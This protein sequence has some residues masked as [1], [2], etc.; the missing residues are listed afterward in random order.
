VGRSLRRFCLVVALL[1]SLVAGPT[2]A[3]QTAAPQQVLKTEPYYLSFF[4]ASG[5]HRGTIL[6]L[7]GGGWI[8][9]KGAGADDEM[10]RWIDA[11]VSWG[12]DV[13]NL[14]YR[15]GAPA[16]VDA[17]DAFE[18][19]RRRVGPDERLCIF[20]GSAGA[21][22]GLFVAAERGKDVDCVVDLLGP[23][24]LVDFGSQPAAS[25]GHQ[26]AVQ[27]FGE[28]R[29]AELS[30]IN[31]VDRI[32]APVLVVAAP[33]DIFI[34]LSAQERFVEALNAAGGS[35][36]LQVVETGEDIPL[37]HCNVDGASF[38]DF[39]DV[40]RRFLAGKPLPAMATDDDDGFGLSP[41]AILG[42]VVG[43]VGLALLGRRLSPHN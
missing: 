36:R 31:M 14:G 37:G 4:E 20:G 38:L 24:D 32:V 11:V 7:H 23:P 29:L 34:E 21:Q 26:L 2:A 15:T 33:C 9:D 42:I 1:A 35:A 6:M 22:L 5:P 40:T 30:P 28:D 25:A 18:V 3:A 19:V 13:A 8:G 10:R 41:P 39:L 12:W 16:L 27:A 43:L 17:L